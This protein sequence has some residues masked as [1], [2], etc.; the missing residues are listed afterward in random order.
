M[1][2][3]ATE[4]QEARA[5]DVRVDENVLAVDLTDGRTI[6]TPLAWYQRLMYVTPQ[7]RANFEIIGDS[8]YIHWPGLDEDLTVAGILAGRQSRESG[9]SLKKWLVARPQAIKPPARQVA[10]KKT[11]YGK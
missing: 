11:K 10:E 4:I 3:L 8:R 2:T 9:E 1:N 7:E 5:M 6:I